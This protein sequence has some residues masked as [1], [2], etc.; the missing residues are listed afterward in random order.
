MNSLKTPSPIIQER[1]HPG[2]IAAV[3]VVS[4]I[5]IVAAVFILRKYCFQRS[6]ATYRYSALRAMEEDGTAGDL[7]DD[8]G[9]VE[10]DSD[11]DILE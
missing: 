6:E 4:L 2:V 1:I 7:D 10:E 11:E 8:C 3:V 9:P 5:A